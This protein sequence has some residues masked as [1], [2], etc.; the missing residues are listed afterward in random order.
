MLLP[1]FCIIKIKILRKK[2]GENYYDKSR[3]Y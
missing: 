3:T 1:S 2:K